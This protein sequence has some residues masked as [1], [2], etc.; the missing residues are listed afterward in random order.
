MLLK[1]EIKEFLLELDIRGASKESIRGYSIC[2]KIFNEYMCDSTKLDNIKAIQI[3]AFAK[4]NKDKRLKIK[5]QN[6]YI[7]AI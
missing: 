6:I 4:F 5:T 1:D 7:S 2:L 3:K